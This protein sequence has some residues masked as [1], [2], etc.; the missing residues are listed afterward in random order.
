M[1]PGAAGPAPALRRLDATIDPEALGAGEAAYRRGFHHALLLAARLGPVELLRAVEAAE[2]LR[3]SGVPATD[4][5]VVVARRARDGA[6]A[7][8]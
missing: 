1:S 6:E 7:I 4:Y 2:E 8:P 5:S 3:F